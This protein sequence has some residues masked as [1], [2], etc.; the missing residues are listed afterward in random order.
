MEGDLRR[1]TGTLANE[2]SYASKVTKWA[3]GPVSTVYFGGGTPSLHSAEEIGQLLTFVRSHWSLEPDA[4]VTLET[5]PGT[6]G[7]RELAA[8]RD[9]GVNRLSLGCQSF[10]ERKLALLYRDHDIAES[11]ACVQSAR[12][13]GF[14]NL[15]LDLIFGLPGETLEEWQSDLAQ[16][17]ELAPDHV[18]LYNLEYHEAT[19]YGRWRRHGTL[20]PLGEDFEADL[21]LHTHEVMEANGFEHY[22]VSNFAKPGFRSRHNSSYWLGNPYLGLGPS[23]HSFD[24]KSLRFENVA[25]VELW[26]KRIESGEST[27]SR[28]WRLN[29]RDKLEE[30]I[31]LGL[32]RAE[33]IRYDTAESALGEKNARALWQ[34]A[35]ELPEDSRE[36]SVHNFRLTPRGWFKEN[37]VL[38]FLYE[39]L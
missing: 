25:D 37:S 35:R 38:A 7:E 9:A 33:G 5:N 8:L 10:S 34:R 16:A 4:E 20:V 19:V 36:L 23:A 39:V 3:T 30:W 6:V 14:E 28:E 27:V 1:F 21:Y 31:S 11:I 24:G 13:A 22:E 29:E 32:R 15:S 12:N 17:L 18:S 26:R 2:I